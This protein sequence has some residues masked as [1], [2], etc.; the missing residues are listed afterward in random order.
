[1]FVWSKISMLEDDVQ[2]PADNLIL[3]FVSPCY[4]FTKPTIPDCLHICSSAV[5]V[6][7]LSKDSL[8]EIGESERPLE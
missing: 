6:C 2:H 8:A 7:A 3:V 1:M 5:C 4:I